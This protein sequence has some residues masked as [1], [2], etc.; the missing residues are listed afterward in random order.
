[1]RKAWIFKT[2]AGRPAVAWYDENGKRRQRTCV[3]QR[4]ARILKS[5]MEHRLNAG[6]TSSLCKVKWEVL[7]EEYVKDKQSSRRAPATIKEIENTLKNFARIC[8]KLHSTQIVQAQIDKFKHLRGL[9]CKSGNTLNKDL[10][11]LKAFIRYFSIDRA[12]ITPRIK[13]R[14]NK[15]VVKPVRALTEDQVQSLLQYLKRNSPSYYIRALLALSAGLRISHIENIKIKDIHIEEGTIDTFNIKSKKWWI[16]R[17][18]QKSVMDEI[19]AFLLNQNDGR[20][21]LI[22]HKYNWYEWKDLCKKAGVK[23]TFHNLRKTCCSL[24]QQRGVG[25][26]VAMRILE[27]EDI[28]TTIKWYSDVNPAVKPAQD[29]LP[30]DKWINPNPDNQ[31]P[32]SRPEPH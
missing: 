7:V 28:K 4:M 20:V 19:A 30:V 27:H 10:A 14:L 22:P 17:P 24:L 29:S 2:K 12:Y 1:M 6:L 25:L 9:E 23:T 31:K 13:I 8:G 16:G 11:N 32:S 15:T 18:I 26:A 3:D 5:D 21:L